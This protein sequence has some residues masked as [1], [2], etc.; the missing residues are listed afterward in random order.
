MTSHAKIHI[1]YGFTIWELLCIVFVIIILIGLLM[2]SLSR[3]RKQSKKVVCLAILRGYSVS[4]LMYLDDN[5]NDFPSGE[6]EWLYAEESFTPEHPLGCRWHDMAMAPDGKMMANNPEYRG[7]M[8]D[9][10]NHGKYNIC[11]EFRSIAGSRG[12]ES[13]N[14][15]N[16]ITINP[17]YSYVI[18]SYLGSVKEGGVLKGSEVRDPKKV[19]FF[20]EENSW[21]LR[22][23]HP[24][25]PAS[26]LDKPLSN[27]ALDDT[28]LTIS[29]TEQAQ[30]C[31]AT[32]H[33]P[34]SRSYNLGGSNVVFVDG[35]VDRI[36]IE[37]Q[38]NNDERG[39]PEGMIGNITY[40]WAAKTLPVGNPD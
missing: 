39:W 18:N 7:Q 20:A 15:L 17:Q 31:F 8:W 4:G 19:F 28:M 40:A 21:T 6:N 3:V 5:N 14:H 35:H 30:D 38:L 24:R 26:G 10:L 29:S 13:P 25:Y 33:E 22:P 36:A 16:S 23:D 12:C 9:Y 37:D 11:P 32:Y 27:R 2:P 1:R 34:I